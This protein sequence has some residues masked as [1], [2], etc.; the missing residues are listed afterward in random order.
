MIGAG[1][2][3]F[4]GADDLGMKSKGVNGF[5]FFFWSLWTLAIKD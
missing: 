4:F 5:A 2:A 3:F 1:V